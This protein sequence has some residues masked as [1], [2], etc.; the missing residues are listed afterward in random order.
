MVSPAEASAAV[1]DEA[2]SVIQ[3]RQGMAQMAK[4]GRDFATVD[5]VRIEE[6][7][8]ERLAEWTPQWGF[9]GEERGHTGEPDTY[10][11][12][13]P[14]DGTVNYA[15]GVPMHGVSLALIRDG[16]PVHGEIALPALGERYVGAERATCNGYPITVAGTTELADCVVACGDFSTAV[17]RVGRLVRQL[18]VIEAV[19]TTVARVRMVGSAATDLAWVASGRVDALV[20]LSNKPWDTTAGVRL[21]RAAG[22]TVTHIDGSPWT[23]TGPDVL[24]AAPGVHGPLVELLAPHRVRAAWPEDGTVSQQPWCPGD[25]VSNQR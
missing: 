13:D 15:R 17:R 5:D 8:R 18:A 10:W 3:Q 11:C 24:A 12:L 6:W 7:A 20:M 16:Q 4:E 2:I 9:L 23:I 21:A 19:A 25:V 1:V 22:A 14:I